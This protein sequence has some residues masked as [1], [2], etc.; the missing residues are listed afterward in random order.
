ML[1]DDERVFWKLT[2]KKFER[3]GTIPALTEVHGLFTVTGPDRL[4]TVRW[5]DRSV[6][7]IDLV[8]LK[9]RTVGHVL[10]GKASVALPIAD[11]R[12][13]LLG[14]TLFENL[15]AEP[16]VWDAT[17]GTSSP[18]AGYDKEVAKQAAASAKENEKNKKKG[19][20]PWA[21]GEA[22]TG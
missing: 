19:Y 13:L 14:G 9:A 6:L 17:K 10:L 8:T 18:I 21:R 2:G 20:W 16:E 12:V 7:E 5:T 1:I 15:E 3:V 11:Q 22:I 4:V